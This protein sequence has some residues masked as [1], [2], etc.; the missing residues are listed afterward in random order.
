MNDFRIC[1]SI[2]TMETTGANAVTTEDLLAILLNNKEKA[3]RLI[4]KNEVFQKELRRG[5]K[6]IANMGI[7]EL[8]YIGLTQK[9]AAKITAAIELGKRIARAKTEEPTHIS[10]P[11]DAAEY[12]MTRLRDETHERFVVIL[13]NT[14]NRILQTKQIAEGSL[15]SA[16]VH[17]REVFAP[18]INQHAA[19]IIAAHNH[20][21]GD[22][23]PSHE[24]RNLTDALNKAGEVMGIPLMDHIIIG[25]N[26]YYSFR[27][28]GE[29]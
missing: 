6:N 7:N 14:K 20:P 28:H 15:T 3:S 5:L 10:S 13:L 19:C 22:P 2:E 17:P 12:L 21:S 26:K 24:D 18:A 29:I 9:E 25:D 11:G 23:Y 1:E 4:N 8:K 16:V 27:E